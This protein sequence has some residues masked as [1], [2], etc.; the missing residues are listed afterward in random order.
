MSPTTFLTKA[1]RE[2]ADAGLLSACFTQAQFSP[3][4]PAEIREMLPSER[5]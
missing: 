3:K 2:A 4:A 1:C 5:T